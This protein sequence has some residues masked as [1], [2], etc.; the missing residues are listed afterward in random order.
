MCDDRWSDNWSLKVY[1]LIRSGVFMWVAGVVALH[2]WARCL[3]F[4][5]PWR[6]MPDQ[7]CT[8]V[9]P[10]RHADSPL[11]CCRSISCT[12]WCT[13]L[14]QLVPSLSCLPPRGQIVV[15]TVQQRSTYL[16]KRNTVEKS[17]LSSWMSDKNVKLSY[18]KLLKMYAN[19]SYINF[20][21]YMML[22]V[23]IHFD[24]ITVKWEITHLC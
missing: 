11:I 8:V 13:Y 20:Y 9:H 3:Q 10:V 4:R 1:I 14:S 16:S 7:V 5:F 23:W 18:W 19:C 24:T 12:L 21:S 22:A 17:C 15:L 2:R 6:C